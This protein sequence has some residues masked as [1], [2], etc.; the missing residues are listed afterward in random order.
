MIDLLLYGRHDFFLC[1]LQ[2]YPTSGLHGFSTLRS[3]RAELSS[4]LLNASI[5]STVIPWYQGGGIGSCS[6]PTPGYQHSWMPKSFSWPPY[7]WDSTM[8]RKHIT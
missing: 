6:S 3:T 1:K 7:P 8:D 4:V 2:I 5:P